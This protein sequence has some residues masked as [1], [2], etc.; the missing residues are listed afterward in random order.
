M[1]YVRLFCPSA[2]KWCHVSYPLVGVCQ[3]ETKET[4]KNMIL[5]M[6]FVFLISVVLILVN[7]NG[8]TL[9]AAVIGRSLTSWFHRS[10]FCLF[11]K[12]VMKWWIDLWRHELY[13]QVLYICIFCLFSFLQP[14]C[15]MT[16][17]DIVSPVSSFF[18][19]S[20]SFFPLIISN[21]F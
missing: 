3:K 7:P 9:T 18:I 5:L 19:H 6:V 8:E 1:V 20:A 21:R 17:T 14:T 13:C 16:R 12:I 11:F 4:Q 10:F 15:K 2:L